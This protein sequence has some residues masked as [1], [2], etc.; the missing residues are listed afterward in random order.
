MIFNDNCVLCREPLYT[1]PT[2][3]EHYVHH[4]LIRSFNKL[5]VPDEFDWALRRDCRCNR[6]HGRCYD[7]NIDVLA[8]IS[9]HKEWATVTV[10][11]RCNSEMSY[12]GEA[13]KY[14]IDNIDANLPDKRFVDIFYYYANLCNVDKNELVVRI[15]TANEAKSKYSNKK[16]DIVYEPFLLSCGRIEV[17]CPNARRTAITEEKDKVQ[18]TIMLGTLDALRL[19]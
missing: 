13:F 8:P 19:L 2:N 5:C 6:I 3:L 7:S 14:I 15:L 9:K 4:V 17:E 18:H 16:Y 1:W 12:I 10:H 11:E